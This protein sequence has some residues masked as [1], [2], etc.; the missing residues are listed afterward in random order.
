[1][2]CYRP[3][4]GLGLRDWELGVDHWALDIG[5]T[6]LALELGTGGWGFGSGNG[7][8]GIVHWAL[9]IVGLPTAHSK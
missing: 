6:H 3:Q 1:M 2:L 9:E 4:I 7:A 5:L 8:L